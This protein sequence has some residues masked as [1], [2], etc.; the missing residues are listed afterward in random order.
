[1][2]DLSNFS[3]DIPNLLMNNNFTLKLRA[4][5]LIDLGRAVDAVAISDAALS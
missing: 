3:W 5:T 2:R 1:M 4:V